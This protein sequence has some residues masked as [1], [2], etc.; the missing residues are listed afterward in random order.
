MAR[1]ASSVGPGFELK[2]RVAGAIILITFAVVVL[3]MILGG[4]KP[5]VSERAGTVGGVPADEQSDTQV[6]VSKITPIGGA[7]PEPVSESRAPAGDDGPSP[8]GGDRTA[9]GSNPPTPAPPTKAAEPAEK[10][11]AK[12]PG[13]SLPRTT[14]ER[15]P[16]Q[17][18]ELD[19]GW[20]VRIGTYS[21][22]DNAK[23]VMETL[24]RRG[25]KPSSGS[26]KTKSG[27]ATRVWVGPYAQRVEAA[28]ARTRIERATGEKGMITAFP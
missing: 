12:A 6:F 16:P 5:S 7:T 25:F 19:R 27:V 3:P 18:I 10:P 15:A 8:T 14:A 24:Q 22:A 20:V 13:T 21:Q 9:P 26:V 4:P 1:T 28:R 17:E 2:H 23:R 11:V